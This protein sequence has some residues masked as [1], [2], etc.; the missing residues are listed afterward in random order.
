MHLNALDWAVFKGRNDGRE[1]FLYERHESEENLLTK[2]TFV[3]YNLSQNITLVTYK[4]IVP[5]TSRLCQDAKVTF[6]KNIYE[7]A[8]V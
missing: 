1:K 8:V 5:Q 7:R 2:G 4:T 3:M 6:V